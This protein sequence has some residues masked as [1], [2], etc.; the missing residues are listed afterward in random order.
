MRVRNPHAECLRI[1]GQGLS[2]QGESGPKTRPKG[3]VDGKQVNIPVPDLLCP[4]VSGDG[5]GKVIRVL[6]YPVQP[7]R[8]QL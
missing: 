7:G 8:G 4:S 3:V 2:S 6:V 1:P 5:D